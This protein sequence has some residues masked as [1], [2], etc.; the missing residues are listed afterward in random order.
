MEGLLWLIAFGV[1][2]FV[3]MRY[4]CGAHIAHGGHGHGGHTGTGGAQ[5]GGKDPVCGMNVATDKGYSMAWDGTTYRFCSRSCLEKFEA[6]P[7]K[8]AAAGAGKA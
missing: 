1:L 4:G 7:E 6:S 5:G 8:F 3:M 2:F